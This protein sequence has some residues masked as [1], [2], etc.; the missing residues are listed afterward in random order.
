MIILIFPHYTIRR[1]NGKVFC[2]L[3]ERKKI[4][5]NNHGENKNIL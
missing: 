2:L 3:L 4:K 1:D 5:A